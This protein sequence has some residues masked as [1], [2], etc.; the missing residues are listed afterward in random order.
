MTKEENLILLKNKGWLVDPRHS[1]DGKLSRHF[2]KI[3]KTKLKH[4][5]IAAI[6]GHQL[7]L[8]KVLREEIWE[9]ENGADEII[10]CQFNTGKYKKNDPELYLS[11][12]TCMFLENI[13]E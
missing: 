5:Q 9:N 3:K 7:R 4:K 13:L 2:M 6:C 8:F 11:K 12:H 10:V 1:A